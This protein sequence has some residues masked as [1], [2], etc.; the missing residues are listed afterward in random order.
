M[1]VVFLFI[2]FFGDTQ[3]S[4]DILLYGI[5][6]GLIFSTDQSVMSL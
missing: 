4:N 2:L 1:F 5:A 6:P 3:A